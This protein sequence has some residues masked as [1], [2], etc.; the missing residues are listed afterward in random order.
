MARRWQWHEQE[1][2]RPRQR[3]RI[4]WAD[5]V[6]LLSAPVLMSIVFEWFYR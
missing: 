2:A 1:I 4:P 6:I 5:V 3:R